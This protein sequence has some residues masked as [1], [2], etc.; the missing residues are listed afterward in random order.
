MIAMSMDG[1]RVRPRLSLWLDFK[2]PQ[3]GVKVYK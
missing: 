3:L 1:P 2:L